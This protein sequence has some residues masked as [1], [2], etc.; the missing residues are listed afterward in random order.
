MGLGLILSFSAHSETITP[1][2][3]SKMC[4][5]HWG[6]RQDTPANTKLPI[7]G[8]AA[9]ALDD[10]LGPNNC[11]NPSKPEIEKWNKR[12]IGTLFYMLQTYATKDNSIMLF[13]DAQGGKNERYNDKLGGQTFPVTRIATTVEKPSFVID[14]FTNFEDMDKMIAENTANEIISYLNAH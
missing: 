4:M 1:Q 14:D 5:G 3:F 11:L 13:P 2:A 9:F 10:L 6:I 8:K 7:S 12:L